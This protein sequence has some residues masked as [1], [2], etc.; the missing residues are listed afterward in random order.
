LHAGP[1]D[2]V[3]CQ[4]H[5]FQSSISTQKPANSVQVRQFFKTPQNFFFFQNF[6]FFFFFFQ[7]SELFLKITPKILGFRPKKLLK[8]PKLVLTLFQSDN[9]CDCGRRK[10]RD[11]LRAGKRLH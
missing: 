10:G 9:Q 6:N 4:P 3:A 1:V 11:E 8:F 7:N 5:L 2:P